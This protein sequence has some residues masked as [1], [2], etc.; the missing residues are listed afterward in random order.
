MI[1]IYI[2]VVLVVVARVAVMLCYHC[3]VKA[4]YV[5]G[6]L[7]HVPQGPIVNPAL[8]GGW[9]DVNTLL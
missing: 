8:M 4:L 9:M 7:G 6:G 2:V 3:F 5:K 1:F